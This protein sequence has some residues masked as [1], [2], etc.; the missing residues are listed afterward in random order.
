MKSRKL[1]KNLAVILLILMMASVAFGKEGQV[2]S[3]E[4]L[5]QCVDFCD[6]FVNVDQT[7]YNSCLE[8]F[9]PID[10]QKPYE[11]LNKIVDEEIIKINERIS[12]LEKHIASE[13]SLAVKFGETAVEIGEAALS[14]VTIP[15][16]K[17]SE[18]YDLATGL[19]SE[20]E[21]K[22]ALSKQR[23][24]NSLLISQGTISDYALLER[25]DL[26]DLRG[27]YAS[28]KNDQGVS[29]SWLVSKIVGS[30]AAQ[31]ILPGM[32][33]GCF[34]LANPI[35]CLGAFAGGVAGYGTYKLSETYFTH[36]ESTVLGST[37][38]LYKLKLEDAR[39]SLVVTRDVL[40][41]EPIK[42]GDVHVTDPKKRIA[43]LKDRVYD[44]FIKVE[45][46]VSGS[47]S[48]KAYDMVLPKYN[49]FDSQVDFALRAGRDVKEEGFGFTGMFLY[50][51][52]GK[53]FGPDVY[54]PIQQH[55]LTSGKKNLAYANWIAEK[56]KSK[57]YFNF[58]SRLDETRRKLSTLESNEEI[59]RSV[60]V[61]YLVDNKEI[62]L[63]AFSGK[64]FVSMYNLRYQ[65]AVL[66]TSEV[67]DLVLQN[68]LQYGNSAGKFVIGEKEVEIVDSEGKTLYRLSTEKFTEYIEV[69][70]GNFVNDIQNYISRYSGSSYITKL[71]EFVSVAPVKLLLEK[72]EEKD[73]L[74]FRVFTGIVLETA[75]DLTRNYSD[76]ETSLDLLSEFEVFMFNRPYYNITLS[77]TPSYLSLEES[78]N[79]KPI[80]IYELIY[81]K[82]LE[83]TAAKSSQAFANFAQ[84]FIEPE[85]S[86]F[87]IGGIIGGAV[88]KASTPAIRFHVME[89]VEALNELK[90]SWKRMQE[91]VA[92]KT[93]LKLKAMR[94]AITGTKEL[95]PEQFKEL[96]KLYRDR[97]QFNDLYKLG[98]KNYNKLLSEFLNSELS[99]TFERYITELISKTE[100]EL[101]IEKG[102]IEHG[103]LD[104][105][106]NISRRSEG[107]KS[108]RELSGQK[109]V[110][111][112]VGVE[113]AKTITELRQKIIENPRYEPLPKTAAWYELTY[114]LMR[115]VFVDPVVLERNIAK[116]VNNVYEGFNQKVANSRTPTLNESSRK[117]IQN[118]IQAGNLV[119]KLQEI[120]TKTR[121]SNGRT[122]ANMFEQYKTDVVELAKAKEQFKEM[123]GKAEAFKAYKKLVDFF[124]ENV[125]NYSEII[126]VLDASIKLFET[127]GSP[128]PRLQ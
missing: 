107:I 73:T 80:P 86:A 9:S 18:I 105:K 10:E 26:G 5:T 101:F 45:E 90:G 36:Q 47:G 64:A 27:D 37:L 53:L 24:N 79:P 77:Y 115:E 31:L 52:L 108:F 29:N 55:F 109:Q 87:L 60:I 56:E 15:A 11:E 99:V 92:T 114:S 75:D 46:V 111:A 59:L 110:V 119:A 100:F 112:Q 1:F 63:D 65:R 54:L 32:F 113:L 118:D 7:Q 23:V 83:A 49:L 67:K 69:I 127:T 126:K 33:Y 76:Y 48:L 102:N 125:R 61:D 96:V 4:G 28:V 117:L 95:T 93:G 89:F 57:D 30:E 97:G 74:F 71:D 123:K 17:V 94:E 122:L 104:L 51:D 40:K 34:V 43:A 68:T 42:E 39:D 50:S 8:T 62:N 41:C 3:S 21:E 12:S 22:L 25:I 14:P 121:L 106:E 91:S 84:T 81:L 78:A 72:L 35:T 116:M 2:T 13:N 128:K 58:N 85:T 66:R 82:K 120:F 20:F 19:E 103:L 16:E 124:G 88:A 98:L 70:R 6:Q 44:Y 38:G